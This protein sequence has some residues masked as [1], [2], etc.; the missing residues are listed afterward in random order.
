MVCESFHTQEQDVVYNDVVLGETHPG[1]VAIF[2]S[3]HSHY[4]TM[5]EFPATNV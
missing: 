5:V 3:T 2:N 1:N 4:T